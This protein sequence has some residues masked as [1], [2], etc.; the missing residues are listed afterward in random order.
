MSILSAERFLCFDPFED[1]ED[2][3]ARKVCCL[4]E[5]PELHLVG[6]PLGIQ[7]GC[8]LQLE[9]AIVAGMSGVV[10]GVE[11]AGLV[12]AALLVTLALLGLSLLG[13]Y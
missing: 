3:A 8:M 4:E 10:E 9:Q 1:C 2:L 13:Q 6:L 7:E 11:I 5:S 12:E